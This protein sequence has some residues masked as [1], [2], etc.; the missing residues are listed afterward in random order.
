M[1]EFYK[2]SFLLS[3]LF[4]TLPES[5]HSNLYYE[6]E[7]SYNYKGIYSQGNYSSSSLNKAKWK[8]TI[9]NLA[10]KGKINFKEAGILK[11]I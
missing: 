6:S 3:L 8:A 9:L 1:N 11:L 2:Y 7:K 5:M 4:F 10:Y